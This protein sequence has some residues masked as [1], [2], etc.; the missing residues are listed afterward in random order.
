MWSVAKSS[1]VSGR[2]GIPQ[3]QHGVC[4]RPPGCGRA[5]ASR[6]VATA[7]RRCIAFRAR[8][9]SGKGVRP[10]ERAHRDVVGRPGADAGEGAQAFDQLLGSGAREQGRERRPCPGEGLDRARA[11]ADDA[12]LG[13]P[14]EGPRGQGRRGRKGAL[15]SVQGVAV[16]P[17]T[18]DDA[19]GERGRAGDRELL[20]RTA[21]I[22]TR[23]RPG[24]PAGAA[25][26]RPA[27]RRARRRL[28][29]ARRR[30]RASAAPPRRPRAR[31]ASAGAKAAHAAASTNRP[32]PSRRARQRRP[33]RCRRVGCAGPRGRRRPRRP[34]SPAAR[35]SEQCTRVVRGHRRRHGDRC[36]VAR[37]RRPVAEARLFAVP[38]SRLRF[39]R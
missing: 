3:A 37:R 31:R 9:R 38:R 24:C 23:T 39:I 32:R 12:E 18:L 15:T 7:N 20:A 1:G 14:R 10:A 8:C 17:E 36:L 30:G 29:G 34:E 13:E 21:R 25:P 27:G 4:A 16:G 19:P 6:G 28:P 5:S 26:A 2:K 22:A 33:D 35:G 11:A